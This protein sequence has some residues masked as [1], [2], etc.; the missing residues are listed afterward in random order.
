MAASSDLPIDAEPG[1]PADPDL[2][3]ARRAR[4]TDAAGSTDECLQAAEAEL[5]EAVGRCAA[6]AD[7][8]ERARREATAAREGE[9][10]ERGLRAD[11]EAD[12]DAR[13][14]ALEREA[15]RLRGLEAETVRLREEL[16]EAEARAASLTRALEGARADAA[17]I[18][19]AFDGEREEAAVELDRLRGA[20]DA[21][22]DALETVRAQAVELREAIEELRAAPRGDAERIAALEGELAQRDAHEDQVLEALRALGAELD[23]ARDAL[24]RRAERDAQ[25]EALV[26]GLIEAA[27]GLRGG[28]EREL[29]RLL[30]ER[31]ARLAH[32]RQ[33]L[34]AELAREREARRAAEEALRA[35]TDAS[36]N[37]FYDRPRGAAPAPTA[38][39][40]ALAQ[41]P[42]IE[43]TADDGAPGVV[44]DLVRAAARLRAAGD[45]PPGGNDG[46]DDG[47]AA[48]PE[49]TVLPAPSPQP[50][51][52]EPWMGAAFAAL[53]AADAD[54]AERLLCALLPL[55]AARVRH[56]VTYA[57]E[58]PGLGRRHVAAGPQV[59]AAVT[60]P[61]ADG[62]AQ[63]T[64]TGSAA[65]LAPLVTGAAPRRKLP[66]VTVEGSRWRLRRLL[67]ALQRP[68]GLD[69]LAGGTAPPRAADLL[70]LLCVAVPAAQVRG[71]DFRVAYEVAGPA[72]ERTLV[73]AAPDGSLTV[74]APCDDVEADA[75]VVVAAADLA[76]ILTGIA[77]A[78]VTGD[79][80]AVA[81][82][83]GWLRRV[84]RRA[85]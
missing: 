67:R 3:A 71:S 1:G 22:A 41:R 5:A 52:A 84:Q 77:P 74:T 62:A 11:G 79:A 50:G 19:E 25:V 63:F 16:G 28:Y 21:R 24:T 42:E 4:R 80:E 12:A 54:A 18:R 59:A 46:A 48:A 23:A 30:A 61:E 33:R 34:G 35:A 81:T 65:A 69:E 15:Q 73:R 29:A 36:A 39:H 6:L 32:E 31:D 64:L 43:T 70:A 49:R 45:A 14:R 47:R 82:L 10:A 2:L 58:L 37:P 55:Q 85:G 17:A 53:A 66:G 60:Q 20:R 27:E 38:A 83:Q 13:V 40:P 8:L 56:D 75:T 9:A 26:A 44:V 7:A 76:G 68:T 78:T 57:L 72:G 51:P